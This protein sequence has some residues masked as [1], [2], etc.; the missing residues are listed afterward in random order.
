MVA[1]DDD[2][3]DRGILTPDDRKYLRGSEEKR[4]ITE[5][6]EVNV[7]LRIR[8]RIKHALADFELLVHNLSAKDR[9]LLFETNGHR[10]REE[11]VADGVVARNEERGA[12]WLEQVVIFVYMVCR[13]WGLDFEALIER[14]V[15]R[16]E[17]SV[18]LD[19]QF[20]RREGCHRANVTVDLQR[21]VAVDVERAKQR[22]KDGEY[23]TLPEI[24]GLVREGFVDNDDL[25][26][27]R[28]EGWSMDVTHEESD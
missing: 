16:A 18:W 2:S 3:R 10:Q 27:F 12:G 13:D 1:V 11:F 26:Q 21:D 22:F 15:T 20:K 9:Q 19:G 7:R 28:D 5:G 4:N 8:N 6:T 25:R 24:G 17:T 23:L 14:A